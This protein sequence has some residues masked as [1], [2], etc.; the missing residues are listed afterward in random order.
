MIGVPA[1][2]LAGWAVEVPYIGRKGSLAISSGGF[3][4]RLTRFHHSTTSREI[5]GSLACFST[6]APPPGRRTS[7]WG[8]TVATCFSVTCVLDGRIH[9]KLAYTEGIR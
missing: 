8:G 7:F 2:F 5:K 4:S 6:R 1:A 9:N 3:P